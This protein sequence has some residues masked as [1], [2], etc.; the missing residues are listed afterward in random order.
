MAPQDVKYPRQRKDFI[1]HNR[2]K[3]HKRHR[4]LRTKDGRPSMHRREES[5]R[6]KLVAVHRLKQASSFLC[7]GSSSCLHQSSN[8]LYSQ[9]F[10]R[11]NNSH[12][13]PL[14]ATPP[15]RWLRAPLWLRVLL[16]L[17]RIWHLVQQTKATALPVMVELRLELL[18][19][20]QL[21]RQET[22]ASRSQHLLRLP[23]MVMV[24][25]VET[26]VEVMVDRPLQEMEEEQVM[27]EHHS[28]RRLLV[29]ATELATATELT[30]AVAMAMAMAMAMAVA[31]ATH[32]LARSITSLNSTTTR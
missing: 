5:I 18:V 15:A 23:P 7:R 3:H 32:A 21:L 16:Q 8:S 22:D 28:L 30:M 11:L 2:R 4:A 10:R 6:L 14:P 27:V 31:V 1:R 17:H 29:T 19:L 9:L 26:T 20:Q 25:V 13:R 24:M 12:R